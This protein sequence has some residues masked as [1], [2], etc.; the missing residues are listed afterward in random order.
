MSYLRSRRLCD[1]FGSMDKKEWDGKA[2]EKEAVWALE[3]L[4]FAPGSLK[5][6]ASQVAQW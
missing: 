3:G 6:G 4:R 1:L 2:Q 5:W